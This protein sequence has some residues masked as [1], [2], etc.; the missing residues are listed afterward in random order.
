[1]LRVTLIEKGGK[2]IYG[3]WWCSINNDETQFYSIRVKV[4]GGK[5]LTLILL[6]NP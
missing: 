2:I 5:I 1:M 4:E 6:P 3:N